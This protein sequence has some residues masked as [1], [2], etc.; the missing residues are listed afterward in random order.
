MFKGV[1]FYLS[2][3]TASSLEENRESVIRIL[4]NGHGKETKQI[5]NNTSHIICDQ[6]DYSNLR[7]LVSDDAFCYYVIPKWVLISQSLHYRLPTVC[8][9]FRVIRV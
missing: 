4:M 9:P 5:T 3:N 6:V 7:D 1:L 8:F 2:P